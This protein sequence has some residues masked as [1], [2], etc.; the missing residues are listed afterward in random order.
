M[1]SW[2]SLA[3]WAN[4]K[5]YLRLFKVSD[6]AVLRITIPVGVLRVDVW[7]RNEIKVDGRLQEETLEIK[8]RQVGN[9]VEIEVFCSKVGRAELEAM[10]PRDCTLDLK[11]LKGPIEINGVKG[12]IAA[13]TTEGDILLSEID[14]VNVTAKTISGSVRYQGLVDTTGIYNFQSVESLIEVSLPSD[15]RFTL[16]ATTLNGK[17]ELG[18]FQPTNVVTKGK[19]LMGKYA[20]GGA[21]LNLSTQNGKIRLRR[22][23]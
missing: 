1:I 9:S 2:D 15:S 18:E 19:R 13:Q 7:D 11:C 23:K 14:S 17:V 6:G 21:M 10:V 5:N 8:D 12:Q 16:M 3:V 20:G 4:N 22:L